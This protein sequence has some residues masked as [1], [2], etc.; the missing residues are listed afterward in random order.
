[1]F[2][3][4][5][6]LLY[7]LRSPHDEANAWGR[8]VEL[9]TP[10]LFRWAQRLGEQDSDCADLVQDVFLIL[11]RKLPEFEYD[12]GKSFHAWL[13]TIFLNRHRSRLR[14]RKPR[15]IDV[16]EEECVPDS[17]EHLIN[18]EETRYLIRQAYRLIES[19]FSPLHQRIFRLYALEEQGPEE[20][21]QELG[22]SPGTVYG[23]K[24]KILSRLRQE[25]QELIV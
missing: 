7:R 13:K 25:L 15:P 4:P 9:Y 8:F 20:V 21:A 23:V 5:A 3:T 10:L 16:G 6:S 1:M 24:S 17:N 19:E 11:W 22:I 2:V 14:Q 12:S 18:A